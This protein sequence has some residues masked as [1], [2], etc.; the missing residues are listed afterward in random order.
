LARFG[1]SFGIDA[2]NVIP[3]Q[4][5]GLIVIQK[6]CSLT[7]VKSAD[8]FAEQRL[9][10]EPH[11]RFSE[12][13]SSISI[14]M[15]M[16]QG[17]SQGHC[18]RSALIGM[19]LADVIKLGPVKRSALFYALLLKDLGCSSNASKMT[20]L[21]KADDHQIKQSGRMI[22]WTKPSECLK[23]CW[24]HCAPD[25]HFLTKMVSMVGL[26]REAPKQV[27]AIATIRCE[28]G[29]EIARM[30][31]LPELTAQAIYDLDELWNGRGNPNELK[32]DQI[33]LLG[34]ICCLAQ[35]VEVFFSNYGKSS[36][37]N[38]A[39]RRRKKWFDPELVDALL[40]FED[41]DEFWHRLTSDDLMQ[42]LSLWEP[43][44]R[45]V[46]ANEQYI[47][48]VAEALARVVDAKSPWTY[49]HST[50][51]AEI[52]ES[53]AKQFNCPPEI[54][55]DL[56]RAA[57]LHD[58]GKLGVS[59]KILDKPGKPTPQEFEQI[60]KH[61]DYTHQILSSVSAF[62]KLADVASAH[63]ERLDGRGYH[64]GLAGDEIT[65]ITRLLTVADVCE[66][67]SAARPYREAMSWDRIYSIMS[68]DVGTGIDA[69]CFEALVKAQ[70]RGE[71]ESRVDG[72]LEQIETQFSS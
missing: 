2:L 33:S 21:F 26:L 57:L 34:R 13:M 58:V 61:P 65:W 39:K 15:D 48:L 30:L 31:Q 51:V 68:K 20:F 32:G 14:A 45:V 63:H 7:A 6:Q 69:E 46:V 1:P 64:L 16:T 50:R 29:A 52:A 35:T 40:S 60:R 24:N 19:R 27:K 37:I 67:M 11:V 59:N 41:D 36:A 55:R 47:D 49:R 54:M 62:A 28:R 70:E 66:A 12:I 18:M 17:H 44:D 25:E 72:Q 38:V 10:E 9:I 23:Y 8:F 56:R 3:L 71:L 53:M 5:D 42:E 4:F 43:S 22:D